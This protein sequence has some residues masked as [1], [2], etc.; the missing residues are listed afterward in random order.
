MLPP[1]MHWLC[2]LEALNLSKN[3][4]RAPP[5]FIEKSPLKRLDLSEN[6]I[7]MIPVDA[8]AGCT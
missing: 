3:Y 4:L 1:N 7:E 8:L 2:R 6:K 5:L